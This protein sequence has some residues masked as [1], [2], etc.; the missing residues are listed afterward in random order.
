MTNEPRI[1]GTSNKCRLLPAAIHEPFTLTFEQNER[2][3]LIINQETGDVLVQGFSGSDGSEQFFGS[4]LDQLQHALFLQ[5]GGQC[6]FFVLEFGAP[7]IKPSVSLYQEYLIEN[8]MT[9][10]GTLAAPFHTY[11]QGDPSITPTGRISTF[12]TVDMTEPELNISAYYKRSGQVLECP[13]LHAE[14]LLLVGDR[15]S[16]MPSQEQ[17]DATESAFLYLRDIKTLI[18][19]L[20]TAR[21]AGI[22]QSP[23]TDINQLFD[24]ANLFGQTLQWQK[25]NSLKESYIYKTE[26]N[27]NAIIPILSLLRDA[28]LNTPNIARLVGETIH[29]LADVLDFYTYMEDP[30]PPYLWQLT[31]DLLS[32]AN[33]IIVQETDPVLQAQARDNIDPR[34]FP[35]FCKRLDE[36]MEL[37]PDLAPLPDISAINGE[38]PPGANHGGSDHLGDVGGRGTYLG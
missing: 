15:P 5:D 36:V 29:P 31:T 25:N 11:T 8:G 20:D 4:A 9:N 16:R 10:G 22:L 26:K 19:S 27:C 13:P 24:E 6:T 32:F 12:F 17:I 1:Y 35:R 37:H 7:T 14:S 34:Y 3:V 33:G 21:L 30:V 18:N 2:C 28:G 38:L 23:T